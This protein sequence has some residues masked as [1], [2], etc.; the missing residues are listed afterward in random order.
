MDAVA[1]QNIVLGTRIREVIHLHV[2]DDALTDETQA[3]LPKHHVVDGSLANQ[4]FAFQVFGLVQQA[5]FFVA[6]RIAVG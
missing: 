6:F 3:V 1:A 5:D 2:V 4:Q